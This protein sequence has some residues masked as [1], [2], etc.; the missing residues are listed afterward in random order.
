MR[1]LV[2]KLPPKNVI[3]VLYKD[4]QEGIEQIKDFSVFL[5]FTATL[6]DFISKCY[7]GAIKNQ[8]LHNVLQ[9]FNEFF[10]TIDLSKAT[11]K[12]GVFKKL[13]DFMEKIIA[14][15]DDVNEILSLEPFLQ[16]VAYLPNTMKV[17][18]CKK[19]M[20]LFA[21]T[22]IKINNPMV[23]NTFLS[24]A[25][26]L[27]EN[28]GFGISEEQKLEISDLLKKFVANVSRSN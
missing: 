25:Q 17:D 19:I 23:S 27:N 8:F 9:K 10:M 16:F 13:Q 18:I 2:R 12:D 1:F 20:Y 6:L 5:N 22:Q 14:G 26:N 7:D 28:Y 15:C 24:L 21:Q 3:A 11:E 4:F